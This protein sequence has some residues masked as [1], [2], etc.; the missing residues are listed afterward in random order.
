MRADSLFRVVSG[1][2]FVM[3]GLAIIFNASVLPPLGLREL[4]G[5]GAIALGAAL[6]LGASFKT[7]LI[8]SISLIVFL[9]SLS[10]APS[11]SSPFWHKV[12][13]NL[14]DC[15]SFT[16]S[17]T[18]SD[19]RIFVGGK[20]YYEGRTWGSASLQGCEMNVCCSELL[21]G[22]KE[23]R[24][25]TLVNTQSDVEG[26]LRSCLKELEVKTVL[27]STSLVYEVPPECSGRVDLVVNRGSTNL[28]LIV[29]KGTRVVYRVSSS[30]GTSA[31]ATPQGIGKEGTFG[32]GNATI[33]L[34][35]SSNMG[36]LRVSIKER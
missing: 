20:G 13:G 18:A 10:S 23:P 5:L 34:T 22:L 19:V 9:L 11:L 4:L 29:P 35:G 8:F 17:A 15:N 14:S 2:L 28:V 26:E 6:A 16:L 27:G 25:L 3:S 30:L 21:V 7:S 31:V 1:A 12:K 33:Y 36:S 24:R 32:T